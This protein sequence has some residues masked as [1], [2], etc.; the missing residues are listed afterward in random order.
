M[1]ATVSTWILVVWLAGPCKEPTIIVR[2]ME[3]EKECLK[4]YRDIQIDVAKVSTK[5]KT[6]HMCYE[7]V[8][9]RTHGIT[10]ARM[11]EGS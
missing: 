10:R 1:I 9:R 8:D 4:E 2:E 3:S 5:I 7:I 6:G 11:K